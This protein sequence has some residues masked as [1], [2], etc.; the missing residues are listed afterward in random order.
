MTFANNFATSRNVAL[1]ALVSLLMACPALA[2]E[3]R[4]DDRSSDRREQQQ[5]Q[6]DRQNQNQN[7][8]QSDQQDRQARSDQQDRRSDQQ[9]DRNRQ[10]RLRAEPQGWVVIAADYDRDGRWDGFETIYYYD[11][12]RAKDSSRQRAEQQRDSRRGDRT[13]SNQRSDRR[14]ASG[15]RQRQMSRRGRISGTIQEK[16]TV[17][18]D[19]EQQVIAR[20]RNNEGRTARVLLGK[21]EDLSRLDL[22]SGDRVQVEGVRAKLNNDTVLHATRITSG[23]RTV[24]N[25][26]PQQKTRRIQGEVVSKQTK[27]FGNKD[28]EFV[29]ATIRTDEGRNQ[30]VLLGRKDRLEQLD[31]QQ[32]DQVKVTA[33]PC[34]INDQ[35][36][37]AAKQISTDGRTVTIRKRNNFADSR[38][39]RRNSD[40]RR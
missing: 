23:D 28:G 20:V 19:G 39:D 15:D 36:A 9:R 4:R 11:L 22:Q 7:S 12:Q 35:Q 38:G 3:N 14:Q 40:S 37:L 18:V 26:P 25:E 17:R 13:V 6:S 32:G 21:Q 24:R 30:K 29:M 10:S 34:K 5:A 1:S 16:R 33:A 2:Q 31:L 8:R 27:T